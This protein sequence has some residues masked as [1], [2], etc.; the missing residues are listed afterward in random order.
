MNTNC[1][2]LFAGTALLAV[3]FSSA[4]PASSDTVNTSKLMQKIERLEKRIAVLE[5]NNTFTQFM[6]DFSERFHVLHRAGDAGDWAVASHELSELKR[7]MDMSTSIDAEKGKLM[8]AMLGPSMETL[9]KAIEKGDGETF[10]KSMAQAVNTC[11]ACHSATGSPFI[12]VTL[13]SQNSLGMR[14]PHKFMTSKPAAG[15][16]HGTGGHGMM[17]TADTHDDAAEKKPHIDDGH[18]DKKKPHDEKTQ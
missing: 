7:L 12:Q 9:G 18:H 1:K 11:N 8:Q 2:S 5:S 3:F 14:H 15:H 6:P 10:Q 16:E 4:I 17:N 13:N